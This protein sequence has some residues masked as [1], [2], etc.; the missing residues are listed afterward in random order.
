M[1]C[2]SLFGRLLIAAV[3]LSSVASNVDAGWNEF[4]A[5]VRT[6]YHRNNAWPDPFTEADAMSVITAFEAQKRNGWALH[7]TLAGHQFRTGDGA[8]N[9]SGQQSLAWIAYQAP[10]SRRFVNVE[11]ALTEQETRARVEAV[12]DMLDQF[13][14]DGP[15]PMIAITDKKPP[16]APGDWATKVNRSWLE[17]LAPPKLPSS[18]AAGTA[19]ATRN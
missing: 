12:R 7:N 5:N 11:R 9:V 17:Q 6:G 10:P 1:R 13:D 15:A 2:T 16:T 18:S 8:L 4:W 19:S 3:V 14:L